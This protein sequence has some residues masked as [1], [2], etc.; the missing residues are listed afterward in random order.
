[1][2][3]KAL[4]IVMYVCIC[5]ALTDQQVMKVI[6]GGERDARAVHPRLGCVTR[7]GK[8]V[9]TIA[10][11]MEQHQQADSPPLAMAAE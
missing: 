8:C 9:T 6:E 2:K 10:D 5:N 1:M 4:V 3:N 7:C 11:M